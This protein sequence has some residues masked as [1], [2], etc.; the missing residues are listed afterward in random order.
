[1]EKT[2]WKSL[3]LKYFLHG[4]LFSGIFLAMPFAWVF[5]FMWLAAPLGLFIGFVLGMVSIFAVLIGLALFIGFILGF[6]VFL[7]VTGGINFFLARAIWSVPAKSGWKSLLAQG[8]LLFVLLTIVG[9][10]SG[11]VNLFEPDLA[12]MIVLFFVYSF[13]DGLV[14]KRV[15]GSLEQEYSEN[16]E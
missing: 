10:P 1:M 8:F 3:L 2:S 9:I 15:A 5:I 14:A 12:T 13:I 16:S 11:I 6:I 4:A 7:F